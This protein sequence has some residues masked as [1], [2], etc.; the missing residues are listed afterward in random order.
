MNSGIADVVAVVESEKN[1]EFCVVS[2]DRD[3]VYDD[4]SCQ[5]RLQRLRMS[6]MS[7]RYQESPSLLFTSTAEK[8]GFGRT[9]GPAG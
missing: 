4:C 5:P 7:A 2:S 1:V 3:H 9:I 8:R 6:T